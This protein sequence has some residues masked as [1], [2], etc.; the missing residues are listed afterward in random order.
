ML[1]EKTKERG[2]SRDTRGNRN[3]KEKRLEAAMKSSSFSLIINL[4]FLSFIFFFH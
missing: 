1:R 2:E 4:P 3:P